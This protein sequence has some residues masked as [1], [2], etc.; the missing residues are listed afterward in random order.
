MFPVEK[1]ADCR[2]K[3]KKSAIRPS[4]MVRARYLRSPSV[5][6]NSWDEI[7]GIAELI[8]FGDGIGE[9]GEA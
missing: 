1:K 5:D 7:D 6:D 2:R 8:G 3:R 4:E 9:G